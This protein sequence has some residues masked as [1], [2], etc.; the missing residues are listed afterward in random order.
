MEEYSKIN[1]N[2]TSNMRNIYSVLD[3]EDSVSY[4][5]YLRGELSTYSEKTLYNYG[6]MLAQ[7]ELEDKN[8]VEVIINFTNLL[9]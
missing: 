6:R 2:V 7:Y 3:T 4:E 5:T 9:K 1:P 8:Y